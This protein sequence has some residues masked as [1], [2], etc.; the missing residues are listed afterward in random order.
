[1]EYL[2]HKVNKKPDLAPI[3]DTVFKLRLFWAVAPHFKVLL[4]QLLDILV[5]Q[6]LHKVMES[7]VPLRFFHVLVMLWRDLRHEKLS[8]RFKVVP[9]LLRIEEEETVPVN[10]KVDK[11]IWRKTTKLEDLQK[12]IIVILSRKYWCL[13]EEL[14]SRTAQAPHIYAAIIHGHDSLIACSKC[15]RIICSK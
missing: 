4:L 12:L 10:R 7:M 9:L 13:Y 11:I 3:E 6:Q 2:L 15:R 1:L 5:L 8:K 14:D